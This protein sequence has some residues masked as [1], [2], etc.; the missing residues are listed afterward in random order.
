[1]TPM[2]VICVF[3]LLLDI[4]YIYVVIRIIYLDSNE[5]IYFTTMCVAR[6]IIAPIIYYERDYR[7]V[8]LVYT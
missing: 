7:H 2:V 1:M 3:K 6:R 8:D 5:C 4:I